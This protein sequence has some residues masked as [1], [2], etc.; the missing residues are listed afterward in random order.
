MSEK[1]PRSRPV[2]WARGLTQVRQ[3]RLSKKV[4]IVTGGSRGIGRAIVFAFVAEGASVAIIDTDLDEVGDARLV[5]LNDQQNRR[6]TVLGLRADI[7]DDEAVEQAVAAVLQEFGRID[8]LVNNAAITQRVPFTELTPAD[9]DA[10]MAVNLK[11]VFLVCRHV[12][13]PML[14]QGGGRIINVA[15]NLGQLGS[16][17]LLSHYSAAKAGVIGLTKSLAREL[18]PTITVNAIA[19]GPTL[20]RVFDFQPAEVV[21]RTVRELPLARLGTPEGV[22]PTAVFLASDDGALYT[23]QTLG[24]NSGHV[25]L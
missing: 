22:A 11:G 6:P 24:P 5:V 12:V 2:R 17:S 19:P 8:I 9:W 18:A 1:E 15:S 14:S 23:G 25:M 21:E 4:A 13:P 3:P 16:T 7:S 20:T 10:T